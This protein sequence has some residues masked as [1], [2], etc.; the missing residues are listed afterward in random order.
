M[1]N[2]RILDWVLRVGLKTAPEEQIMKFY[3]RTIF[4]TSFFLFVLVASVSLFAQEPAAVGTDC[5][6]LTTAQ[7][8][9]ILRID[10][11]RTDL[12]LLLRS[13]SD[14]SG[15]WIDA[16][17]AD[18]KAAAQYKTMVSLFLAGYATN[19]TLFFDA[20]RS[21]KIADCYLFFENGAPSVSP[22]F[23]AVALGGRSKEQ[24]ADIR[25]KLANLR[26]AGL[27]IRQNFIRHGYL[28]APLVYSN[29][30]DEDYRAYVKTR[31][32]ELS[33][34]VD[35][36]FGAFFASSADPMKLMFVNSA[37]LQENF[38]RQ[39]EQLVES[40]AEQND[41][42]A[43][44]TAELFAETL[45]KL[46]EAT[47]SA[48][49]TVDSKFDALTISV[50]MR[51]ET[52]AS[53]FGETLDRLRTQLTQTAASSDP[54]VGAEAAALT[55]RAVDLLKPSVSGQTLLWQ[56]DYIFFQAVKSMYVDYI[57]LY[58]QKTATP[59]APTKPL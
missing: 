9:A 38:A 11:E 14:W 1:A 51:S 31:F 58:E 47:Q 19:Y 10:A 8:T 50:L 27:P 6:A 20:L 18:K 28:F 32:S 53:A 17:M 46:F 41:S 30:S 24:M 23:L 12:S 40:T 45:P 37:T 15:Q 25:Q 54:K 59:N 4:L 48:T 21:E 33:A 36:G 39:M 35:S 22:G 57:T 5:S 43:Q 55:A 26:S 3:R 52:E 49:V 44:T 16:V 7:T 34:P 2:K 42:A 29:V 56:V 13:M